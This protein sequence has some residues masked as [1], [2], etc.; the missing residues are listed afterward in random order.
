MLCEAVAEDS[1]EERGGRQHSEQHAE[2]CIGALQCHGAAHPQ[3]LFFFMRMTEK[4]VSLCLPR[5]GGEQPV[6]PCVSCALG[7]RALTIEWY[8]CVH[9]S[10]PAAMAGA[11]S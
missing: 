4:L 2:E 11:A 10:S 6:Q 9:N 3:H 7:D 8:V 5:V 1:D